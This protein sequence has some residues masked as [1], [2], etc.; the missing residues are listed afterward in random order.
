MYA[1]DR[2]YKGLACCKLNGSPPLACNAYTRRVY[3]A[4]YDMFTVCLQRRLEIMFAY[5]VLQKRTRARVKLHFSFG[6]V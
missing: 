2:G 5:S 6:Y 3:R 4:K 1:M